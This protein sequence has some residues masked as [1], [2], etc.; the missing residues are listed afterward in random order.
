MISRTVG[1]PNG[2]FLAINTEENIDPL[3]TYR[4]V[5]SVGT[6]IETGSVTS[7]AGGIYY[8]IM[9]EGIEGILEVG[10]TRKVV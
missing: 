8:A 3:P 10:T 9:A 7:G 4:V 6:E 5:N 2:V 1:A